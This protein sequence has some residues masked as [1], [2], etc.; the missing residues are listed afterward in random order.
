MRVGNTIKD[1]DG[2][3]QEFS[4]SLIR[5]WLPKLQDAY[6]QDNDDERWTKEASDDGILASICWFRLAM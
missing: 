4:L 5:N 3:L 2:G 6:D 1:D